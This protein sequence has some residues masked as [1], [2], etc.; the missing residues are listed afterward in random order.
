MTVKE[1]IDK[2]STLPPDAPVI[3]SFYSDYTDM[4]PEQVT[5]MRMICR[6]GHWMDFRADCWD[7]EQDGEPVLI[8]VCHFPGN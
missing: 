5:V 3:F 8:D 6:N 1:L 2:L 4:E 7:Y